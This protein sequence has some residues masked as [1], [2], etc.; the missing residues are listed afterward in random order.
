MELTLDPRFNPH[1]HVRRHGI[2]VETPL[3]LSTVPLP[4]QIPQGCP[5]YHEITPPMFKFV[6]DIEADILVG[7]RV[8][9]DHMGF[10]KKNLI[11]TEG[12]EPNRMYYFRIR[13]DQIFCAV[14]EGKIIPIGSYV[15]VEPEYEE[16]KDI[17]KPVYSTIRGEDGKFIPLPE[18]KWIQTKVAPDRKYLRGFVRHIGKPLKNDLEP[19]YKVGAH[20]IFH[21]NSDYTTVI[22]GLTC[23]PIAQRHILGELTE[24]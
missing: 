10:H 23:F 17:L 1:E 3:R 15:L 14:R 24:N 2:V 4:I 16:W 8:W 22:E 7:D 20:V 9:F 13:Y 5:I 12:E 6:R 19:T 18:S 11:L 21:K